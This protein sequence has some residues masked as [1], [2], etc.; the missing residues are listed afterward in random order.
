MKRSLITTLAVAS[1]I[2]LG[3][4]GI[5]LADGHKGKHGKKGKMHSEMLEKFDAD[6]DGKLSETEREAARLAKFSDVDAD[7][8]GTLT[9][10]EIIA[11]LW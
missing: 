4:G 5:A 8:S 7:G 6:G 1:L 2:G 9:K 3:A 10:E 11:L